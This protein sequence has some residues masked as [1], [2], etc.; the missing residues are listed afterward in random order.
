MA[1]TIGI[2]RPDRTQI[3]TVVTPG[4]ADRIEQPFRPCVPGHFLNRF[5]SDS[6]TANCRTFSSHFPVDARLRV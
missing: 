3:V 5:V 2:H 6:G 1:D 4:L